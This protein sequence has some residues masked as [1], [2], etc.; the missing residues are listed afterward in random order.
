MS[1]SRMLVLFKPHYLAISKE[2]GIIAGVP[3]EGSRIRASVATLGSRKL[4]AQLDKTMIMHV[5]NQPMTFSAEGWKPKCRL[6]KIGHA[7]C[8]GC[9]A[10]DHLHHRTVFNLFCKHFNQLS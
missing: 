9:K 8:Q 10:R 5:I 7:V 6:C 1:F 2:G 4:P 3:I